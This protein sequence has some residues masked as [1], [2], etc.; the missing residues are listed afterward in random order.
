[1]EVPVVDADVATLAVTLQ[2]TMTVAAK[3]D[4]ASPDP[5]PRLQ[6]VV[7]ED[8][9]LPVDRHLVIS[10]RRGPAFGLLGLVAVVIAPDEMLPT[11]QS[12]H[13]IRRC[14]SRFV[15]KV[16]QVPDLVVGLND[17]IPVGGHRRVHLASGPW[18]RALSLTMLA[19]PKWVSEVKNVVVGPVYQGSTGRGALP[20]E[21]SG[22]GNTLRM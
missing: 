11:V 3:V 12:G 1:M 20:K 16:A 21:T 2:P 22:Y 17:G 18:E 6:G 14:A 15:G 7:E 13:V 19:W 4:S 9:T 5:P 8:Q 10:L